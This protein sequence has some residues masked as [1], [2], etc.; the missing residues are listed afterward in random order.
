MEPVVYWL[1]DANVLITAERA[2]V[3]AQL[4]RAVHGFAGLVKEV[5]DEVTR[6]SR[7]PLNL[8][9]CHALP[10]GGRAAQVYGSWRAPAAGANNAG[11]HASV[12]LAFEK[13]WGFV[14]DEM[15][16]AFLA[17]RQLPI[18]HVD[19]LE[20]WLRSNES[21]LGQPTVQAMLKARAQRNPK[22]LPIH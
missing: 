7:Y 6:S 10:L 17:L 15:V 9:S 1:L 5:H 12:A 13:G 20:A 4:E 18:C 2:G 22:A 11:E 14:T 8:L 16:G 21:A 3:E 19:S